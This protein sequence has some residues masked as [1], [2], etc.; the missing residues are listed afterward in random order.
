MIDYL[1]EIGARKGAHTPLSRRHVEQAR[2]SGKD[3]VSFTCPVCEPA[4]RQTARCRIDGS[5][6]QCYADGCLVRVIDPTNRGIGLDRLQHF[7]GRSER[8]QV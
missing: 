4:Y 1:I 5:L 6:F 7:L 2:R 8:D 3:W